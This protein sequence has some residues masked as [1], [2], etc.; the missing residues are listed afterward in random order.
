MS[1][2]SS[3]YAMANF[4]CAQSELIPTD[5]IISFNCEWRNLVAL[6][7][8]IKSQIIKLGCSSL[9]IARYPLD[10]IQ[11]IVGHI[12]LTARRASTKALKITETKL[13]WHYKTTAVIFR[14]N[15]HITVH[16]LSFAKLSNILHCI[17]TVVNG[18]CSIHECMAQKL[19]KI[20]ANCAL[21]HKLS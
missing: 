17:H 9:Q 19:N 13:K 1:I 12:L 10:T 4:V 11:W 21:M 5:N 7:N 3:L 2:S 15:T 14:Q 16:H 8:E 18:I 20:M 6:E